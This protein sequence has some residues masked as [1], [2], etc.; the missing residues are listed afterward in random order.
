MYSHSTTITTL[1]VTIS[2]NIT[3]VEDITA[4]FHYRRELNW[5]ELILQ[6]ATTLR[7][8]IEWLWQWAYTSVSWVFTHRQTQSY[9]SMFVM[10][11]N[12]DFPKGCLQHDAHRD[13]LHSLRHISCFYISVN[14]IFLREFINSA[15]QNYLL[16]Y[17]W[18]GSTQFFFWSYFISSNTVITHW[19]S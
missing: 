6:I 19:P 5:Q 16:C 17:F 15:F 12:T 18:H 7:K 14:A 4:S 8:C 2:C 3:I 1:I 9:Y 10:A 13:A 11:L